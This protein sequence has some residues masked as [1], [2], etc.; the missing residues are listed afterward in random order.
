MD[1]QYMVC[2]TAVHDPSMDLKL[3]VYVLQIQGTLAVKK[4][5]SYTKLT[6]PTMSTT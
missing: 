4:A 2:M 3:I 1:L 5:V 6:M